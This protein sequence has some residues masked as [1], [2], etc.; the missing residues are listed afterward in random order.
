VQE[1]QGEKATMR[2]VIRWLLTALSLGAAVWLVPGIEIDGPS[3]VLGIG[4][5]AFLLALINALVQA[6]LTFVSCGCFTLTLAFGML[7][8]NAA[9]VWL[10]GRLASD[11]GIGF[12]VDSYWA[13]FLGGLMVSAVSFLLPLLLTTRRG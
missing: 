8:I 2:L 4:A 5:L 10:F 9:A 7:V 1:Q 6:L 11:L 13:A 12:Y 3:T